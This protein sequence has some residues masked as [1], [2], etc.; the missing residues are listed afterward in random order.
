MRQ[1]AGGGWQ[2]DFAALDAP[3]IVDSS[4]SVGAAECITTAKNFCA[5]LTK[6]GYSDRAPNN[7]AEADQTKKIRSQNVAAQEAFQ[8]HGGAAAAA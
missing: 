3:E 2:P 1:E 8:E 7:G 5:P 4:D 6:T